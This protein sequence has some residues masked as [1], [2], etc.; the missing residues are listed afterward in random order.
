MNTDTV[1]LLREC[2]SGVKMGITAIDDVIEKVKSDDLFL[3]LKDSRNEHDKLE[4]E[5]KTLLDHMGDDD[6][7]PHPIAKSMA[8]IKCGAMLSIEESDRQIADVI[9]DGCNMG[10]KSLH[11]YLNEYKGADEQSKQIARRLVN[12]EERLTLDMRNYL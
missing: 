5:I 2:S 1:R 11:R 10:V 3:L 8:R 9:T 6:K 7:E 4:S 12:I